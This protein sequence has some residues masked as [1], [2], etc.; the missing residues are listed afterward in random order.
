MY[1]SS[2]RVVGW[3]VV[4]W[5]IGMKSETSMM[6]TS[7]QRLNLWNVSLLRKRKK[8]LYRSASVMAALITYNIMGFT[9]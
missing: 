2:F 9:I 1:T 4:K 5:N 7:M 8:Q 3:E 6:P